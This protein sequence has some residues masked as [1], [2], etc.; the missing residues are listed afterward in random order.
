MLLIINCFINDQFAKSFN[1]AIMRHIDV[2]NIECRIVNI[3]DIESLKDLSDFTHLIISGSEVSGLEENRWDKHLKDIVYR[4]L[5]DKKTILGICYG[6]QFLAKSIVGIKSIRKA[7]RPEMGWVDINIIR[8]PLFN[9]IVNPI[10]AV[11]HYDEVHLL[12]GDFT[13]IASSQNCSIQ[14]FQYKNLPVWGIQFHPEYNLD[15]AQ[16]LFNTFSEADPL[17]QNHWINQMHYKNQ[18]LQN[19]SFIKNFLGTNDSKNYNKEEI[20]LAK[21]LVID[22]NVF[23]RVV[24]REKLMS[25]G[26]EVVDAS[27]GRVGLEMFKR[28]KIDLVITDIFMPEMNGLEV[29]REVK[30]I[31]PEVKIIVVSGGSIMRDSQWLQVAKTLGATK[32]FDKPVDWDEFLKT[33][34]ALVF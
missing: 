15:E 21:A 14:G 2:G 11:S 19:Q 22:D 33:V 25:I 18:L 16:A 27:N 4:F 7:V 28:E 9:N 13:V 10:C 29:I 24:L 34:K 12:T 23:M 6:H 5:D 31:D 3:N 26:L 20:R 30:Q 1:N 17:F 32:S 8:N